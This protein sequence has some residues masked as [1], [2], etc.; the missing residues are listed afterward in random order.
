MVVAESDLVIACS[1]GASR[2]GSKLGDMGG[3]L[4]NG[5]LPFGAVILIRP[6]IN[7]KVPNKDYGESI[8]GQ[9]FW[10]QRLN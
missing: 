8:E 9:N 1:K 10:V 3:R 7:S 5:D 2:N 6:P 4:S